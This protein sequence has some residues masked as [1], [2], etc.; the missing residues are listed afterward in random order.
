M[1]IRSDLEKLDL[2]IEETTVLCEQAEE[3]IKNDRS[4]LRGSIGERE[5][6][7][8]E[9]IQEDTRAWRTL[10]DARIRLREC[11]ERRRHLLDSAGAQ[12]RRREAS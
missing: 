9:W 6:L 3:R 2:L 12:A 7:T 1:P 10:C 5:A 11:L 4:V 8:D